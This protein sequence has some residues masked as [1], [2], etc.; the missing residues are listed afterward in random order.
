MSI[1]H[2]EIFS[3]KLLISDETSTFFTTQNLIVDD[4]SLDRAEYAVFKVDI[5]Q[6][7]NRSRNGIEM[8]MNIR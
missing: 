1:L 2:T 6:Q 8:W 4:L 7:S 5:S 3:I